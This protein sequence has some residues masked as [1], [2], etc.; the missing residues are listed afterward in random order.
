MNKHSVAPFIYENYRE[1]WGISE[2]PA[3]ECA[4]FC[5]SDEEWGIFG[6][7]TSC[8]MNVNGVK[9]KSSEHLFQMM[10][11]KDHDIV[12]RVWAGRTAHDK[13][14]NSIKM[15]SFYVFI[16]NYTYF[17]KHNFLVFRNI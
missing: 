15:I 4:V 6:N 16:Y 2:Y 10:K 8:E 7:M 9:F 13:K 1:Y 12:S 3:D 14:C 5:S 17:C 11:F